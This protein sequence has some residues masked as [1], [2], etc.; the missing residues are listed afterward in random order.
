MTWIDKVGLGTVQRGTRHQKKKK[1]R[2]EDLPCPLNTTVNNAVLLEIHASWIIAQIPYLT[3]KDHAQQ[4]NKT[5]GMSRKNRGKVAHP[6][7]YPLY[8][9]CPRG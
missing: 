1:R 7:S 5:I 6:L 2:R 8:A 4:P 3:M 9:I